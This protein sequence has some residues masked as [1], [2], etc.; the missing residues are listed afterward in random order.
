L[1][2][3]EVAGKLMKIAPCGRGSQSAIHEIIEP[4]PQESIRPTLTSKV[5]HWPNKLTGLLP[6]CNIF[7]NLLLYPL[8]AGAIIL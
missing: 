6:F 3:L 7:I 1:A 2:D 5:T 8:D 4:R